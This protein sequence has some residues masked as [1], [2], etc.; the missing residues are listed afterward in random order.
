M[1]PSASIRK[2]AS[3]TYGYLI[4][5]AAPMLMRAGVSLQRINKYLIGNPRRYFAD[6]IR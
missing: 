6:A 5:H 1:R 4:T 2:R 3:A